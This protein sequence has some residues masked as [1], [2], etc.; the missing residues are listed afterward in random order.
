[1][2]WRTS[3]ARS[4]LNA[5]RVGGLRRR[6]VA[7]Q[8]VTLGV[9]DLACPRPLGGPFGQLRPH[10]RPRALQQAVG[11]G[12]AE[13]E[14]LGGLPGR[15]GHGVAQD[16][17]R[18][19]PRGQV[20]D[21]GE[22]CQLDR[23]ARLDHDRRLVVRWSRQLEQPVRV[24]LE[25][26]QVDRRREVGVQDLFRRPDVGRHD[27]LRA[28]RQRVEARIRRDAVEP[29]PEQR[30]SLER[31]TRLPCLEVRVLDEVVG[32]IDRAEHPVAV[33]VELAA[34]PLAQR[35]EGIAIAAAGRGHGRCF[36]G[37]WGGSNRFRADG[38]RH[39]RFDGEA[40][41]TI[42]GQ[43]RNRCQGWR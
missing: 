16:Q 26:R 43:R 2:V 34:V 19:L 18:P 8:Q 25:P 32:V 7:A 1:M 10:R 31:G 21:G 6:D 29:G 35:G 28:A 24:R 42:I 11:G 9:G 14:Q 4:A 40:C 5:V 33:D 36:L 15:P 27:T 23:L 13:V 30:T 41:R 12:L 20:L 3:S 37:R 38:H 17:H 22:V 39:V